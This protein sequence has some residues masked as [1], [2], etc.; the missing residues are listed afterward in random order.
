MKDCGD[1]TRL[2]FSGQG[3][4]LDA[5]SG[6]GYGVHVRRQAE[7]GWNPP[8]RL[9][10]N[11]LDPRSRNPGFWAKILATWRLGLDKIADMGA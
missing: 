3:W 6:I 1:S 9:K 8:T 5:R 7:E 10:I 4:G 2:I 11:D